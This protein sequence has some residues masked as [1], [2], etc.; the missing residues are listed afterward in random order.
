MTLES[1]PPAASLAAIW[2][3]RSAR[4][5]AVPNDVDCG[6]IVRRG[7]VAFTGRSRGFETSG[8]RS[9][10]TIGHGGEIRCLSD[11]RGGQSLTRRGSRRPRTET[12]LSSV[13]HPAVFRIPAPRYD[14]SCW[15]RDKL[16]LCQIHARM[17]LARF[18]AR[19]RRPSLRRA[20]T[21]LSTVPLLASSTEPPDPSSDGMSGS[22]AEALS[23]LSRQS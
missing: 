23:R 5:I 13:D 1:V 19:T 10:P 18:G 6:P 20:W 3:A 11:D 4:A 2:P 12:L 16:L 22:E 21:G 8:Q 14:C 17:V 15:Q 7:I 9:W